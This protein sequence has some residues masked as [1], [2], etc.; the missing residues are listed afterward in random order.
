MLA[1]RNGEWRYPEFLQVTSLI[2]ADIF[3]REGSQQSLGFPSGRLLQRPVDGAT[4]KPTGWPAGRRRPRSPTRQL[5]GGYGPKSTGSS[6][7]RRPGRRSSTHQPPCSS[8]RGWATTRHRPSTGHCST[9]YGS[10]ER[11]HGATCHRPATQRGRRTQ[12]N[13]IY[14]RLRRPIASE[15][16]F[17]A[18]GPPNTYHIGRHPY[19]ARSGTRS[20]LRSAAD[21]RH[22]LWLVSRVG[23]G[24][25]VRGAAPSWLPGQGAPGGCRVGWG[26]WLIGED[27]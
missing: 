23:S 27:P 17:C 26:W 16:R 1:Q 10:D 12:G 8:P 20:A 9:R 3:M 24:L 5:P 21:L 14:T 11:H 22:A 6:R 15:W 4:P 7:T 13:T 2:K 25:M 18:L 19:S